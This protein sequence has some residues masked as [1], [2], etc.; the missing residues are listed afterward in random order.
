[1][2]RDRRRAL[3]NSAV[4]GA[5]PP[6]PA[7]RS[8]GAHGTKRARNTFS[9]AIDLTGPVVRPVQRDRAPNPVSQADSAIKT[10]ARRLPLPDESSGR[11]ARETQQR[12]LLAFTTGDDFV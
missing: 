1:M 2:I 3:T 12:C 5:A 8:T 10:P 9:S 6:Q 7:Q 11:V 4:A